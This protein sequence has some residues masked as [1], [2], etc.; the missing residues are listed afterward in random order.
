MA[1]PSSKPSVLLQLDSDPHPSVFDAVVAVDAGVEHLLRH[2]G[3]RPQDVRN[4]VY[5][6]IFTRGPADLHRTAV[7]LG[8]SD[9]AL[10]EAMLAEAVRAFMGPLRVSV[11]LDAN[12]ANTTAAAAVLAAEAHVD[13]RGA[14][15]LA[16]AGSGA[17]GLRIVQLLAARGAAVRVTSLTQQMAEAACAEVRRKVPSAELTPLVA[18]TEEELLAAGDGVRA[19]LA[20]GPPGTCLLPAAVRLQL[21]GLAVAI[22]LNAVGPHGLEGIDPMDRGVERGGA[23]CYGAIGVGGTKMKIHKA[24]LRRLFES[25]DQVL[26]AEEIFRIGRELA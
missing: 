21:T 6:A 23:A 12:G 15:V 20:S 17:V 18:T 14:T 25:N 2:G 4:L 7:F 13:L 22:D 11:M 16:L 9:T 24:A 1:A 26:D 8:G 5:G 10:G 3:V 19:V